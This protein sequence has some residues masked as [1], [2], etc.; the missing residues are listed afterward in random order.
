LL[1][2]MQPFWGLSS[3]VVREDVYVLRAT[4]TLC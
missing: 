1:P 2:A 3:L 4:D